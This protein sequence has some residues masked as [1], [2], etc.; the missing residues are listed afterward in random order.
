MTAEP[1]IC[2]S[3]TVDLDPALHA[4]LVE[5]AKLH[6]RG[7][8]GRMLVLLAIREVRPAEFAA[9]MAPRGAVL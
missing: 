2:V 1:E 4:E 8:V 7:D 3:V 9:L 6:T 5:L